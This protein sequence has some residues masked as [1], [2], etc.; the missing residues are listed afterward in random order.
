VPRFSETT[1]AAI[2]RAVDIVDLAGEYLT[3]H[4]AGSRFKALCPFHDDHNPSLE[5]N[6]ERQTFKCWSCGTGGDIFDFVKDIE[7]VEFPEA[8][9]MLAERAGITLETEP[10]GPQE[11]TGPTRSDLLAIHE[12]AAG[13]FARALHDSAEAR[14][15]VAR[16]GILPASVER[17]GLGFAPDGRDWLSGLA[18]KHGHPLP[19]L[20][21]AGLLVASAEHP[22]RVHE[23]FRGRL[24][25]PIHDFRGRT[26]AFGG[27]ILPSAEKR[28][29]EAG[30]SVAKYLNSPETIL[31]QKRRQ[32]YGAD[33]ARAEARHLGWVAVVEG[34]TDVIAAHQAGLTNVVATLGTALGDDHATSLRRLA[35][36]VVLV[37]DG[38]EAGQKAADR[39][40]PIFL[41][42]EL[43]VR[44]LCL[45]EGLDPADFIER[46]GADEFR[47]RLDGAI[48][49]MAFLVER[50]RERFDLH[51]AEGARQAADEV[52]GLLA[53]LPLL[54]KRGIDVKVG[55][56]VN[57]LAT[58]LRLPPKDRTL[59]N[60]LQQLLKSSDGRR[61]P[62]MKAVADPAGPAPPAPIRLADLDSTD[63]WLID[64]LLSE[65]T[66]V[67][68]LITRVPVGLL[69]DAPLR[70]ILQACYDLHAEG[71]VPS[72]D[73]VVLRLEDPAVKA[74]AAGLSQPV[75]DPNQSMLEVVRPGSLEERLAGVLAA[76]AERHRAER[77]RDLVE[78]LQEADPASQ[79]DQHR[80]LRQEYFRLLHQRPDPRKLAAS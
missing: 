8:L 56:A 9:R 70:A 16:R 79:P 12:W 30:L 74:L 52:L 3:L 27:R 38:D 39:A 67:G 1:L 53:K 71:Q 49:P 7:K 6:R 66:L 29:A 33:L 59:V 55:H 23:R 28:L 21:A 17:F 34:Y 44:V 68:R 48:D 15:Y 58:L 46:R 69:K 45:P 37:F 42:H 35:D 36:R 62:Q 80:A 47:R 31:F 5:L 57:N 10:R 63:R 76:L 41:G 61:I 2:K 51:S 4:R 18:R 43:D 75:S 73:R 78:A 65:P 24:I 60:R 14:E 40:L 26:I 13:V 72:F 54:H 32:L 64:V 22:S 25:F 19:L 77:L 20:E 11:L 50:A